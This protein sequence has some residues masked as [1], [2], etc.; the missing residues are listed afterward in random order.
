[1]GSIVIDSPVGQPIRFVKSENAAQRKIDLATRRRKSSPAAPNMPAAPAP[2]RRIENGIPTEALE[3]Q[4]LVAKYTD[5]T[6]SIAKRD[7]CAPRCACQPGDGRTIIHA[8]APRRRIAR[9]RRGPGARW[10]VAAGAMIAT[11]V[12]NLLSKMDIWATCAFALGNTAEPLII[13]GL[14]EHYFDAHFSLDRLRPVLGLL[15]TAVGGPIVAGIA[16]TVV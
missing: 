7:L 15:A 16:W 13:A 10:P 1:V 4:M 5:H 3:A 2:E 8:A 14:I 9:R 12:A 6:P 11:I